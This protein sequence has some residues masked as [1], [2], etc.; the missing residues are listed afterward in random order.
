MAMIIE[1]EELER[2]PGK[3]IE[4]FF[5]ESLDAFEYRGEN[6]EFS[7]DVVVEG[8]AV[9]VKDGFMVWGE[10]NTAIRLRCSRCLKVFD[11]PIKVEFEVEY[12]R[13]A[14]KFSGRERSLKDED[15]RVSYFEGDS[16]DI[17]EDIKQFI[18]LSIPMKPL[19]REDCKGLCPVCGKN[20]NEGECNCSQEL[21]DPRWSALKELMKGGA[22]SGGS[23][24]KNVKGSQG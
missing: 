9:K 21:Y 14:E 20:L 13:G 4:F 17:E 23:E 18:I 19:C 1:V 8:G 2:N 16:I 12:R 6:V 3:V 10:I 7:E 15:F 11:L 5:E 24:E 22:S